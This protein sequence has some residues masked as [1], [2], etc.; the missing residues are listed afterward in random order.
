MQVEHLV[1]ACEKLWNRD[2]QMIHLEQL[3]VYRC[4]F[5]KPYSSAD[6]SF[7]GHCGPAEPPVAGNIEDGD[8]CRAMLSAALR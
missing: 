1:L 5:Q 8:F 2:W 3:L 6:D 7:F 4:C